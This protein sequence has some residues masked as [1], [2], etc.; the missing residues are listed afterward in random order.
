MSDGRHLNKNIKGFK[1]NY[2]RQGKIEEDINRHLTNF[3]IKKSNIL[4]FFIENTLFLSCQ[5]ILRSSG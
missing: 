4:M 5:T 1:R 2:K 3:K